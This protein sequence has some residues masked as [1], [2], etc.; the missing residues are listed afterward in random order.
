MYYLAHAWSLPLGTRFAC[1]L[2]RRTFPRTQTP[3]MMAPAHENN[4]MKAGHFLFPTCC[5]DPEQNRTSRC[6]IVSILMIRYNYSTL[7][8]CAPCGH[9][10]PR[11]PERLFRAPCTC[12]CRLLLRPTASRPCHDM[13]TTPPG[14]PIRIPRRTRPQHP[15]ASRLRRK[16][17]DPTRPPPPRPPHTAVSIYHLA[18]T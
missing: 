8:L 5:H 18:H 17:E 3:H 9:S 16:R 15:S 6:Y 10:R 14:V 4:N 11:R 2:A 13:A 7:P 1:S 12:G